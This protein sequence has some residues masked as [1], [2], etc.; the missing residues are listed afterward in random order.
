MLAGRVLA[1][2]DKEPFYLWCAYPEDPST[3][4][5]IEACV[6]LLSEDEHAHWRTLRFDRHRREYLTTR[7]LVRTALSHYHP[8]ALEAWRFR[9]NTYGKP[10]AEPDCGLHFNLSN[11]AGLVVCLIARGVEVGVDAEPINRAEEIAELVPGVLS[12][13]EMD[14]L[15]TLSGPEKVDRALTLWILKEAYIKAIGIGLSF[16]LNKVSFLFGGVERIRLELDPCLGNEAGR[17]WRFCL[18]EHAGHRIAL[19][20]EGATAPELQVWEVRPLLAYPTRLAAGE[21]SWF[22]TSAELS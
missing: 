5:V 17:R 22:P 14:Q 15:E 12:P 3:E 11:S 6:P 10:A 16:P 7:A 2:M 18:T 8:L 19:V 13:L 1:D 20:V 4:G 21:E 9:T